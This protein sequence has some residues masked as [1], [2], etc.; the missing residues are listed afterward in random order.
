[1]TQKTLWA[2]A[3]RE[4]AHKI[5][6]LV[7]SQSSKIRLTRVINTASVLQSVL[8]ALGKLGGVETQW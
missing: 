4:F 5:E 6:Q 7:M 2:N 8:Q 3:R 1:M